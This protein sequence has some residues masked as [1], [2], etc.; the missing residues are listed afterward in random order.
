[1]I[2]AG[3]L[4]P[5]GDGLRTFLL[6]LLTACAPEPSPDVQVSPVD[7]QSDINAYQPLLLQGDFAFPEGVTPP[8]FIQV[9]D[10]DGGFVAGEVVALDEGFGFF[11][12]DPWP[13]DSTFVWTLQQPV[14][15]VRRPQIELPSQAL[16][17]RVF[18]TDNRFTPLSATYTTTEEVCVVTSRPALS[19]DVDRLVVTVNGDPA[20]LTSVRLLDAEQ[21]GEPL[22]PEDN[23]LGGFCAVL[24]VPVSVDTPVRFEA[25]GRSTLLQL[26]DAPIDALVRA[27]REDTA[28]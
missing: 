22:H 24:D 6:V 27:L 7:G 23:G 26:D 2:R 11:P 3:S 16:G 4:A 28:P 15:D 8:T 14:D 17:S 5:N 12:A 13:A 21:L 1:M 9:V 20:V 25:S 19:A 10:L 18:H